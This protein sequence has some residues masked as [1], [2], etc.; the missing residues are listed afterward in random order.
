MTAKN[1]MEPPYTYH[2]YSHLY[3]SHG[4]KKHAFSINMPNEAYHREE[5]CTDMK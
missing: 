5:I 1:P 4:H 3:S 2:L